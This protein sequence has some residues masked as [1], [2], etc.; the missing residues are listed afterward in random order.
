MKIEFSEDRAASEARLLLIA[1]HRGEREEEI[2][3]QLERLYSDTVKGYDGDEIA[4]LRQSD[5]IRVYAE[6]A[7]ILCQTAGGI[8]SLHARLYEM[9][10]GLDAATFVRISKCEIVNKNK[11]LCLDVSLA[12]TVGVT[13]EG[14]IKT[15]TS[16]RYMQKLRSVLG[17]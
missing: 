10:E 3:S 8:F 5:I 14:D 9:E 2:L 17:L 12:G 13:L 7:R 11:I 4:V 15:Y 1:P 6:G 16:R